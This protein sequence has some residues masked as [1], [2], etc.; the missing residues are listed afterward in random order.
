MTR[1]LYSMGREQIL[2]SSFGNTHPRW[3]SPHIASIAQSVFSLLVVGFLGLV[4]QHANKDGSV[5]YALGIADGTIYQQTNGI[6]SYGWLA[7][8]GTIC[9]MLV[10]ILVNIAAPVYARRRGEF[11]V[12][13][14]AIAPILST[15]VL[16]IPLTSFIMPPLPGIGAFFTGLGFAPTPFP[17]NI[18]PAFVLVWLLIG[19]G[20]ALYLYR[21]NPARFEML[22]HIISGEDGNP[23][24]EPE[25]P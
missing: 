12:V 15:I 5:S 16:L 8:I 25:V 7:I 14:H 13:T 22:G 2:P 18:L 9:F 17:L 20:Y 4:I 19:A 6:S 11:R 10:Y 3:K 24:I 23:V 21:S 1:Y